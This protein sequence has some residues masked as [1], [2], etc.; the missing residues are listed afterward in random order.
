MSRDYLGPVLLA[1][2]LGVVLAGCSSAPD[3]DM[4]VQM[5]EAGSSI[6]LAQQSGAAE[7]SAAALQRAREKLDAANRALEDG[8]EQ[9]ALN[10]AEEA[11]LD[12]QLAAARS[13]RRK[14][15]RSL[16]EINRSIESLR[17]EVKDSRPN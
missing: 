17:R 11:E 16:E 8:D 14:A 4:T 6:E 3:R 9:R 1:S 7:Y 5:T 12:A 10:L 15:Q 2:T 13:D